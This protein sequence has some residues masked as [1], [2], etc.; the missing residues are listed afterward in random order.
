MAAVYAKDILERIEDLMAE[1]DSAVIEKQKIRM[2]I[3]EN[4]EP[5]YFE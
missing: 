1:S 3:E 4:S 5:N 2:I